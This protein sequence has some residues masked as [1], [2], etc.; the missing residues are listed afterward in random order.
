MLAIHAL[1]MINQE[2][3]PTI[4]KHHP[5]A[6]DY[7]HDVLNFMPRETI[8]QVLRVVSHRM[9]AI[10]KSMPL[11]RMSR[12]QLTDLSISIVSRLLELINSNVR[13]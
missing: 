3:L 12:R 10:V 8:A 1:E 9:N 2:G 5:T 11:D 4:S 13:V 6:T 7:I